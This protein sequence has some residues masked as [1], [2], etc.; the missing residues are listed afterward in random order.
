M[1]L[2]LAVRKADRDLTKLLLVHGAKFA[3]LTP[4]DWI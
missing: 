4:D 2:Q 3:V 1:P